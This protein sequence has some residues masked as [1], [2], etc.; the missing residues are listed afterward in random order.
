M[1]NLNDL[2]EIQISEPWDEYKVMKGKIIGY[3]KINDHGEYIFIREELKSSVLVLFPRYKDDNIEEI[4]SGKS[5]NV[6]IAE[7]KSL[8]FNAGETYSTEDFIFKGIG[9]AEII[10]DD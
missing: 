6:N 2:V 4:F 7:L 10:S 5:I 1:K 8:E 3:S 9:S